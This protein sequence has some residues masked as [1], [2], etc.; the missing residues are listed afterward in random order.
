MRNRSYRGYK[1]ILLVLA[2]LLTA[3]VMPPFLSRAI[4][5]T[6]SCSITVAPGNAVTEDDQVKNLVLDV[7]KVASAEKLTGE[8]SY[9]P[10]LLGTYSGIANGDDDWWKKIEDN[11]GWKDVAKQAMSLALTT[12]DTPVQTGI[13]A[14]LSGSTKIEDLDPGFYLLIA[15]GSDLGDDYTDTID[16]VDVTVGM[17]D[18]FFYYF[19]PM[20]IAVPTKDADEDGIINTAW[21][22][23]EWKYD[24]AV[25]LKAVTA[26]R[27]GSLIIVKTLLSYETH[28]PAF[29][30][31][32]VDVKDV[33]GES[34]YKDSPSLS[35]DEPGM[36]MI[37][38]DDL[39]A[40]SVA[41]VDEVYPGS[42]YKLV[43]K[44]PE[45]PVTI[46]GE[47]IVYVYFENE[48]Y[49]GHNGG[50][51][52]VNSFVYENGQWKLN[53]NHKDNEYVQE[54]R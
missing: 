17:S 25:A 15:R 16:G 30:T 12:P 48:D 29:F 2:V 39:P 51:G 31:F 47:E 4:D 42:H 40:Q 3:G 36:K 13:E 43:G 46:I 8:D 35:F 21:D 33:Y 50:H 37:R 20:L 45:G 14:N 19:E 32:E 11:E 49:P 27:F 9:K 22:Y 41:T 28:E 34:V 38:I 6:E 24:A 10:V 44:D 53:E 54:V 23:G 7:Y 52:I 26:P 18:R 5:L 1:I